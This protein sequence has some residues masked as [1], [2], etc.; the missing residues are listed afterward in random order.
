MKRLKS[1]WWLG[2]Y[3]SSAFFLS[4]VA[5][6]FHTYGGSCKIKIH[7]SVARERSQHEHTMK[8]NQN[9]LDIKLCDSSLVCSVPRKAGPSNDCTLMEII[10]YCSIHNHNNKKVYMC[11]L[12]H[13]KTT[14]CILHNYITRQACVSLVTPCIRSVRE[15][16][17][18]IQ[19][20][21]HGVT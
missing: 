3:V 12:T 2:W 8:I 16:S 4:E 10:H 7:G 20:W 1:S 19:S 11:H 17:M 14:F 9:V 21:T 15:G 5:M 18:I 13:N 6:K